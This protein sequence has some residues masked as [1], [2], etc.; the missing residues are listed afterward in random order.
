M[1]RAA[2]RL[3]G[4]SGGGRADMAQAGGKDPDHLKEALAEA[5]SLVSRQ[6]ASQGGAS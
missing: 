1:V 4:G 5:R 6:L 3:V 2:A